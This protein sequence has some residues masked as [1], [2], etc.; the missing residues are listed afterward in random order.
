MNAPE[1][2]YDAPSSDHDT[3]LSNLEAEFAVLGT[4]LYENILY[5]EIEGFLKPRHFADGLNGRVFEVVMA[6]LAKGDTVD[7]IRIKTHFA[8]DDAFG[9]VGGF[10]NYLTNLLTNVV[11]V[12]SA[13]YYAKDVHKLFVRR[14]L[15]RLGN[16]MSLSARLESDE[17]PDALLLQLERDIEDIRADRGEK[18]SFDDGAAGAALIAE[19]IDSKDAGPENDD[20]V[21]TGLGALDAKIGAMQRGDLIIIAGRPSMGK[22]ALARN[23]A[24]NVAKSGLKVA[25]FSMEMTKKQVWYRSVA[26]EGYP[27]LGVSIS[28]IVK[29]Q[30]S[31]AQGSAMKRVAAQMGAALTTIRV[32]DT[33]DL[34]AADI[35]RRAK[36]AKREMG[37]LDLIVIDY[38][39]KMRH[40]D[41][42]YANKA[43]LVGE[44]SGAIKNLAGKLNVPAILLAQ[45]NRQVE[46]RDDKTPQLSDL[47]DSGDIEQDADLVLFVFRWAYYLE[48]AK[49]KDASKVAEWETELACCQRIM[50]VI[51]AKQRQGPI[52]PVKQRYFQEYD[53]IEDIEA[54]EEMP[55]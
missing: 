52:G 20:G 48:R 24:F 42:R 21:P 3:A 47:R 40:A 39:G 29:R 28:D 11:P 30:Y 15:V 43:D 53:R 2:R 22:T 46:N 41:R 55:L 16:G 33:R 49:P 7:P 18:A 32:D 14:E 44:S 35:E 36:Q 54:Q 1:P 13:V 9:E 37:G 50:D 4:L 38:L 8:G 27:E 19:E 17:D 12:A 5:D 23:I 25:F 31:S 10:T 51:V 26:C 34:T 6:T 45:L